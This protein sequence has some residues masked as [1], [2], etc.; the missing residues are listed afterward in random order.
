MRLKLIY[1]HVLCQ[2]D[3]LGIFVIQTKTTYFTQYKN[4]KTEIH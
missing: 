4:Y 1:M 2:M 3:R